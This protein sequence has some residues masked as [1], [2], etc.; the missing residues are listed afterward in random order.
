MTVLRNR[1]APSTISRSRLLL[2]PS[3]T[4]CFGKLIRLSGEGG[5]AEPPRR[6]TGVTMDCRAS[7]EMVWKA[8]GEEIIV[9][10]VIGF[11]SVNSFYSGSS[12]FSAEPYEKRYALVN[13]R[14]ENG[15]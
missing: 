11:C 12:K 3:G 6:M 4:N 5:V 1:H 9:R 14:N 15:C 10:A 8:A 7:F 2:S 13:S